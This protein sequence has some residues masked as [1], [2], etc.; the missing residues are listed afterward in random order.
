MHTPTN[1]TH[2]L[3]HRQHVQEDEVELGHKRVAQAAAHAHVGLR[4]DKQGRQVGRQRVMPGD[5][6]RTR[7]PAMPVAVCQRPPPVI[8]AAQLP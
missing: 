2:S 7:G 1:A 8:R 4:E 5:V 6:S 3:V